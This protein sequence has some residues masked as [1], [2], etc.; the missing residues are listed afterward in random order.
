VVG[1]CFTG[2]P[3]LDGDTSD[4]T[5]GGREDDAERLTKRRSLCDCY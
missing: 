1:E 4:A 2:D 5:A 3:E